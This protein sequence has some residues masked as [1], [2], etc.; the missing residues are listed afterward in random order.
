M[1]TVPTQSGGRRFSPSH[2]ST[3]LVFITMCAGDYSSKGMIGETENMD[4]PQHS[5]TTFDT[6]R[7]DSAD[8]PSC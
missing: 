2:L 5:E 4:L 6:F 8:A 3:G 7:H 1:F